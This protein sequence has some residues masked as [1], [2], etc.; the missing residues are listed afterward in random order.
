MQNNQNVKGTSGK[1]ECIVDNENLPKIIIKP[2]MKTAKEV[3]KIAARLEK[4]EVKSSENKHHTKNGK[5]N[6]S[7][8]KSK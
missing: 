7:I 4:E 3:S 5:S 1:H 2:D 8:I 6:A